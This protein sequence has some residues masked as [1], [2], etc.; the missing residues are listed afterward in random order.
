M[1]IACSLEGQKDCL[2]YI[3]CSRCASYTDVGWLS[4]AS[5]RLPSTGLRLTVKL[6][7]ELALWILLLHLFWIGVEVNIY[8]IA[9]SQY[10]TFF[11]GFIPLRNFFCLFSFSWCISLF[12]MWLLHSIFFLCLN[13]RNLEC[14]NLMCGL[15]VNVFTF[16]FFTPFHPFSFPSLFLNNFLF[17]CAGS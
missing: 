10:G 15:C 3:K 7:W 8:C 17:G 16:F 13:R 12:L 14:V 4:T 11:S 5:P 6:L 2:V 9:Q 1:I